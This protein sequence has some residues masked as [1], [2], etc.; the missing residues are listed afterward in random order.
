VRLRNVSACCLLA[1][2]ASAGGA[3]PPKAERRPSL[4]PPPTVV[5][6]TPM[7]G[8]GAAVVLP[9]GVDLL[10]SHDAKCL[11]RV[12]PPGRASVRLVKVPA[13]REHT[14][15]GTFVDPKDGGKTT[16][17]DQT[18]AGPCC[19]YRVRAREDGPAVLLVA[20][21]VDDDEVQVAYLDC[22]LKPRPPPE[23][24]P[25]TPP[26]PKPPEP[27][28]PEPTPPKPPEPVKTFR[29][30]FIYESADTL[31]LAQKAVLYA[32]PVSDLLNARCTK[33]DGHPGWRRFDRD[34]TGDNEQPNMKALW[35]AV[36]PSVTAVPCV[37][38]ETNG[39]VEIIPLPATPAEAIATF[40]RYLNEK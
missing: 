25:P 27:K 1:L 5:V 17:D 31:T 15:S 11:V 38:V 39:K 26:E 13:G 4:P 7:P 12:F 33:E 14:L 37:A 9:E 28:P 36:R 22:R 18:F 20:T 8:P 16:T 10:V 6:P 34:T 32:K 24:K 19:V 40:K 21:G 3:D 30:V 29:V 35:K 2:A 23:P